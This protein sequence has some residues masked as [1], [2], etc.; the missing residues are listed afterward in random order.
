MTFFV[1]YKQ[2]SGENRLYNGSVTILDDKFFDSKYSIVT[3]IE[4]ET[5]H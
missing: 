1:H 2:K 3:L 4:N 5:L